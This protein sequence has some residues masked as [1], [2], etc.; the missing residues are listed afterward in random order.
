ML[1]VGAA[2]VLL[3]VV[4][5]YTAALTRYGS[6]SCS[7][8]SES[9]RHW[10]REHL[11]GVPH[12]VEVLIGIPAL[13]WGVSMRSRRRQGWWVCVFGA[14]ATAAAT[15]R[16]IQDDAT[17]RTIALGEAYSVML[18][19]VVGFIVIRVVRLLRGTGRRSKNTDVATHRPEPRRLQPLH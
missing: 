6:P 2:L 3:V 13:V 15:T 7:S 8:R 14:A 12:P 19:L 10:V 5:V 11:G 1:A 18:G 4:L 16:F 17:F 9:A